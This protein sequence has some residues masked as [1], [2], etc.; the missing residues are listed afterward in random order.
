M[1]QEELQALA[2]HARQQEE[3]ARAGGGFDRR[4]QPEP[5]VL[6][7]HD[8][9]WS[10]SERTPAPSQPGLEAKTA[11]IESHHSLEDGMRD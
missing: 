1:P 5:L 6:V 4:I 2:F 3:D 8:P 9:R 10:F 7:L 11:L